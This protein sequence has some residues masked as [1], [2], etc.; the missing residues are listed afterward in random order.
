M[1]I[2]FAGKVAIG[3]AVLTAVGYVIYKSTKTKTTELNKLASNGKSKSEIS[4]IILNYLNRYKVDNK[5]YELANFY[6]RQLHI[7]ELQIDYDRTVERKTVAIFNFSF[8][9][10]ELCS[11]V[12]QEMLKNIVGEQNYQYSQNQILT[13]LLDYYQIQGRVE[14]LN[15]INTNYGIAEA[16]ILRFNEYEKDNS[17]RIEQLKIDFI[18]MNT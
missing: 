6:S 3:I 18:K 10:D 8:H 15:E 12:L 17:N 11:S 5:K 14:A 7:K 4:Q 2:I 9:E 13:F 1:N 16:D